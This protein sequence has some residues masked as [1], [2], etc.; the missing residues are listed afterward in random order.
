MLPSTSKW[1][2]CFCPSHWIKQPF[3]LDKTF[4]Y[5]FYFPVHAT[6]P[7][8]PILMQFLQLPVIF[9]LFCPDVI[10]VTFSNTSICILRVTWDTHKEGVKFYSEIKPIKDTHPVTEISALRMTLVYKTEGSW[11]SSSCDVELANTTNSSCDSVSA[12]PLGSNRSW[13]LAG[14]PCL[15]GLPILH[16][17]SVLLC[18][19][20][21]MCLLWKHENMLERKTTV[22][23]EMKCERL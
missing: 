13:M 23:T 14:V 4:I 9:S 18:G 11:G 5:L 19:V 1:P 6:C 17:I 20:Q 15:K 12:R 21:L 16:F 10:L 2:I 22:S 3:T 8:H 7:M